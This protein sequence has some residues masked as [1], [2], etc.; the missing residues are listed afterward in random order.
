MATIPNRIAAQ[1]W[2]VLVR[3]LVAIAFGI[4]IFAAPL[5][6]VAALIIVFGAYAFVDGILNVVT[7][8]RFA[9]PDSGNWWAILAQGIVGIAIGLVTFFLPGLTAATLGLLFAFW[10]ILTGAFEVVAAFRLRKN[11]PGEIF[12]IIS[13]ILSILI[14]VWLAANPAFALLAATWLIG[15][16]A[17]LAGFSLVAL[18]F[19]LRSLHVRD[20]QRAA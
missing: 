1:W 8:L 11:V 5:H 13:G 19:R 10:S 20:A 12:L 4:L 16:Y 17:L 15:F 3:A 14:G 9:H 6:A 2:V 7:A 18:A